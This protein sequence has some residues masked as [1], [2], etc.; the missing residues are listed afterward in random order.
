MRAFE[1]PKSEARIYC[2]SFPAVFTT[3]NGTHLADDSG[4]AYLDFFR[5]NRTAD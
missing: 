4:K 1:I 2:R 5:D 3:A